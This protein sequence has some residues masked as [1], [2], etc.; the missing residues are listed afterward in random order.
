[1]DTAVFKDCMQRSELYSYCIATNL[2]KA[3]L[4][5]AYWNLLDNHPSPMC[6]EDPHSTCTRSYYTFASHFTPD[7]SPFCASKLR[8]A[9]KGDHMQLPANKVVHSW[10]LSA[11][12]LGSFPHFANTEWRT[13]RCALIAKCVVGA[14]GTLLMCMS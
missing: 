3:C 8:K 12:S 14:G 9:A 5:T 6:P 1:M 2:N 13:N 4:V 10:E 7:C 11:V